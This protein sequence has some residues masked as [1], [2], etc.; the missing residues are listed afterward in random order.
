[1]FAALFFFLLGAI[2]AGVARNFTELLVGR[3][4]QGIGGGGL[5]VLQEVLVTDLIPLRERGKWFG[6]IGGMWA[7]GSVT[8][9][10]IGGT[11]AQRATWRWIF[12]IN[13]PFVGIALPLVFFFIRLKFPLSSLSSKLRRI[14]FPGSTIFIAS[15]T[16]ILIS[17]SWG[18]ITYSWSSWRTLVPLIVGLFGQGCF[19]L[20]EV[21]AVPRLGFDPLIPL[22]IFSNR[23][24]T[25]AFFGTLVHGLTLWCL[26][27]YMPLYF[28]AVKNESSTLTGICL[29]PDTFTVAPAAVIVGF[30]ITKTG[31]YRWAIWIGWSL[32][33]FGLGLLYLLDVNTTTVQWIF[34]TLVS[35]LGLGM[36]FPSLTF[37]MQASSTPKTLVYAVAAFSFFRL[38]GES[39]GVAV[40]GTVFQNEFERKLR[41]YPDLAGMA[42]SYSKDA[43]ALVQVIKSLKQQI[44]MGGASEQ[45]VSQH[46]EL[47]QAYA[48]TIKVVNI[49]MCGIAAIGGLAS[50]FIEGYDVDTPLKTDQGF[51]TNQEQK[52]PEKDTAV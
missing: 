6:V 20:W 51:I 18:G 25:L 33:T 4:F 45:V 41:A 42:T 48:D 49:T 19:V 29:F 26:L 50:L 8:G 40:G 15:S 5:L 37:A 28:E 22:V 12:Y 21:F 10:I 30:L 13:F 27:Y 7:I 34:L 24:T 38:F 39:I 32:T 43:S 11:F 2:I 47:V 16:A 31:R 44:M 35:G 52:H 9:P 3:S 36:L 14:D 1:M 46:R 17:I 23:T